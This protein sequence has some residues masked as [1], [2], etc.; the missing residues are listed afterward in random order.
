M[1]AITGDVD[2]N[3]YYV[4]TQNLKLDETEILIYRK[5]GR[6]I[7]YIR[8]NQVIGKSTIM[9]LAKNYVIVITAME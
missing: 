5:D 6:E 2:I 9:Q 8:H 7:G 3:H 4:A 1:K